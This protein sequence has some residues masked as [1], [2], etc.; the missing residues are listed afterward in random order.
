MC[1][2]GALINDAVDDLDSLNLH[3]LG[4]TDVWLEVVNQSE[5]G[6][7]SGREEFL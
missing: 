7:G 2:V 6:V 1:C 4:G 5:W 3:N